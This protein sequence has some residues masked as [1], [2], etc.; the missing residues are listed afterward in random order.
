[1]EQQPKYDILAAVDDHDYGG[2]STYYCTGFLVMAHT[3]ATISFLSYWEK[4]LQA[5]PQLNQPIFNTILQLSPELAEVRHRGL[6]ETRFPPG[7][8]YFDKWMKEG[9]KSEQRN[10]KEAIIVVHNNY[11][12]GHDAKKKRF[13]EHGLWMDVKRR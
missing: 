3:H 12:I 2:V 4:E 7:R 6:D 5:N 9:G 1:M 10:K 11:I 8:L 13:E